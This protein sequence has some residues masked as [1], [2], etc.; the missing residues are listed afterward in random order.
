[1]KTAL[2]DGNDVQSFRNTVREGYSASPA[3]LLF[4]RRCR[5]SFPM[6]GTMLK[7]QLVVDVPR[8]RKAMKDAL[9]LQYNK[10][11]DQL[12]SIAP[13]SSIRMKLPNQ[14]SWMLGECITKIAECWYFVIVNGQN[15]QTQPT[16]ATCRQRA[17]SA[18]R[19]RYSNASTLTGS[20]DKPASCRRQ[21]PVEWRLATSR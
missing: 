3:Q 16:C 4:S 11:S 15:V 10:S 20:F 6:P 14:D 2:E 9:R 8:D 21:R 7:P 17:Y 12:A 1:M 5:T 19:A 18:T 13:S